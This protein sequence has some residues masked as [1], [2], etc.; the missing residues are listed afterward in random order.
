[1]HEIERKKETETERQGLKKQKEIM[2]FE[3]KRRKLCN[4]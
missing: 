4:Y 2:N 3:K 1:V